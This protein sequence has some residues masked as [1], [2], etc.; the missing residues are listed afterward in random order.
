[1][2]QEEE[3]QIVL[4]DSLNVSEKMYDFFETFKQKILPSNAALPKSVQVLGASEA[5]NFP[6]LGE[7]QANLEI[8]NLMNQKLEEQKRRLEESETQA[9]TENFSNS[10]LI[11]S[12]LEEQNIQN[13]STK[14]NFSELEETKRLSFSA[15]L[16]HLNRL[17][18]HKNEH[19]KSNFNKANAKNE[20]SDGRNFAKISNVNINLYPYTNKISKV[21]T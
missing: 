6:N 4:P 2:K 11:L 10:K 1:M 5:R 15:N 16:T 20:P 17:N 9:N 18:S 3:S 12:N 21:I 7:P 19:K 13:E 8:T 14:H